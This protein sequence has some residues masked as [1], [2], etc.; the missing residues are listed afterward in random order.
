MSHGQPAEAHP[1]QGG[2]GLGVQGQERLS[3]SHGSQGPSP[4]SGAG[5]R[6]ESEDQP[7]KQACSRTDWFEDAQD[8][9]ETIEGSTTPTGSKDLPLHQ[10][11]EAEKSLKTSPEKQACSRADQLEDAQDVKEIIEGSTTPTGAKDF[12]REERIAKAKD[13][14]TKLEQPFTREKSVNKQDGAG[15]GCLENAVPQHFYYGYLTIDGSLGLS[16][17]LPLPRHLVHVGEHLV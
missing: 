7:E 16:Q 11:R 6:E 2:L 5:G 13:L 10:E 8:V 17:R 1:G 15:T 12:L 9:E 4:P 14:V 3:D